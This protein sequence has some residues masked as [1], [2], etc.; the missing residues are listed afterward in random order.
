MENRNII[1]FQLANLTDKESRQHF[2]VRQNEFHRI[3]SEIK[4]DN[5]E[6]SV[7]HFIMLGR[8]GSGK[9]TLLRRIEAEINMDIQLTKKFIVVNLSEEQA[10]IYRLHDVWDT[11]I[12]EMKERNILI[13]E[14]LWI[15][16]L[17]DTTSYSKKLFLSIQKVLKRDKK[18]LILL[19]DN[20]D[21]IF[22][23]IGDESHLLRELL[24]NYNDIRIIGG[25][26]RM[27]EHY[28]KY[29]KPF[30]QF[31]S[32][33]RLEALTADEVKD[34]LLY[35]SDYLNRPVIREFVEKHPGK[36]NTIRVLTD[37]MPRTLLYFIQLLINRPH[38]NGFDYLRFILD[39][40]TPIYQERLLKLPP[41]QRKIVLELS[42]F[43]DAVNVQQ[44]IEKCKM[45]SKVIS[46]QL[47]Q[48]E[49]SGIVEKLKGQ[50]KN[51]LYR[52]SE[53]FFNLWLIMTQGGPMEK[54]QVKY[55]KLF[56]ESWY[57]QIELKQIL[58]E[59]LD[60]FKSGSLKPTYAAMMTKALANLPRIT[61]NEQD[62]LIYKTMEYKGVEV[63]D[64]SYLPEPSDKIFRMTIQ[65]IKDRKF[66]KARK[67]L[68]LID[69]ES[70]NKYFYYGLSFHREGILEEAEKYYLHAID[71]CNIDALYNLAVLYYFEN[72]NQTK[73]LQ[74][75]EQIPLTKQDEK[76]QLFYPICLLW[77]GKMKKYEILIE[78][79]I[80]ELIKKEQ[81]ERLKLLFL[82]LLTHHQSRM[83]WGW[84]T[85]KTYGEP[86]KKFNRPIY[87]VAAGMA[88]KEAKE[89]LLKAGPE[90]EESIE[91][92]KEYILVRQKLYYG[93]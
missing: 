76:Y 51:Y 85:S 18:K 71:K 35:W 26:T 41:A 75:L 59:H 40:A 88:G 10:G 69:Q 39:K 63:K 19:V 58:T 70:A 30:Y 27:S 43:W 6:G 78:E 46:A 45:T 66:K 1:F 90:L 65:L 44:L 64:V 23:A 60:L 50:K 22:N 47:N 2:V 86:L 4:R 55:L 91:Q 3:I 57:D 89:E 33:I 67:E 79:I 84:F 7:Q 56:L 31:F 13:D 11:V 72:K 38:Q 17:D 9:S 83:V 73:V 87:Y 93:K 37:G 92:I 16:Y 82:E 25:S 74:L 53:R 29:E 68:E 34:L 14:V 48:L 42:F 77:A 52:I 54:H 8:R 24:T 20:I 81:L 62:D 15:D 80:P 5:M 21:R 36:L 61:L 49:K 28:W 32:L 12:R